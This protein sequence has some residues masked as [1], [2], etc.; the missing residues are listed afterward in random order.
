MEDLDEP[1][2]KIKKENENNDESANLLIKEE[3]I[4]VNDSEDTT[5]TTPL[6]NH[7]VRVLPSWLQLPNTSAVNEESNNAV[8]KQ[9]TVDISDSD[10]TSTTTIPVVNNHQVRPLPSWLKLPNAAEMKVK[11]EPEDAGAIA[12][13]SK[14]IKT[15]PQTDENAE[16]PLGKI[17]AIFV[18]GVKTEKPDENDRDSSTTSVKTEDPITPNKVA[19]S[20]PCTSAN[21]GSINDDVSSSIDVNQKPPCRYGSSCYRYNILFTNRPVYFFEITS[22]NFSE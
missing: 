12:S 5:T 19:G 14:P 6:V 21:N 22:A 15:E 16:N 11:T 4:D 13:A 3:I 2:V 18:N 20:P 9:P 8:S 1:P 10:G 17:N 7:R